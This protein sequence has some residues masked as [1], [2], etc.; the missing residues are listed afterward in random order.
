VSKV[1][2]YVDCPFKYFS[3][4][5]LRLPE[6]R[7][8]MSGLTPLERGT[9]VHALFEEFYR[10][11]QVE[12][13]GT[14]T[15]AT[16]PDALERFEAIAHAAFAR[17]PAA[18]RALEET[19]LLGSIV[20]RGIAERVFE[21]EA[22]DGGDV[23]DR[24]VEIDLHGTFMFPQL[25]GIIQKPIDIRG[26]ADRIDVFRDGSL[27]IV[28]YKLSRLPDESSVQIGAYAHCAQQWL[29]HRDGRTHPVRAAMYIAFGDDRRLEARLGGSDQPVEMAVA[30]RASEFAAKIELIEA[31][32]FPPRPLRPGDC[33][34]CRFAGV[35]RKEYALDEPPAAE[36]L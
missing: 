9:L 34:F 27:R 23:V 32:Q 31:G 29:Q 1:D 13:R 25:S 24:L 30:A 26:K 18:D 20:A 15:P 2:R 4:T 7:E 8:E 12:G 28:D 35:C 17:L 22:D 16:L 3:E 11:W 33:Q 14:I 21:L 5:I 6:E 36:S 19:R 10:A